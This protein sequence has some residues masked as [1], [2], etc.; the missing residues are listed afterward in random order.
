M[1]FLAF[2]NEEV[3][4]DRKQGF[5]LPS[6]YYAIFKTRARQKANWIYFK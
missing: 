3:E 2:R 6:I 5:D 1:L 4:I